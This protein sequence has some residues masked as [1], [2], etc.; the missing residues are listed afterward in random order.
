[1]RKRVAG[2]VVNLLMLA[3]LGLG[4]WVVMCHSVLWGAVYIALIG[5]SFIVVA[6]AWCAKCPC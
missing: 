5:F 4:V 1:M 3:Y 2:Y 6:Y